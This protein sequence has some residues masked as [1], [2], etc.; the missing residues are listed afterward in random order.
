ME[1]ENIKTTDELIDDIT[2]KVIENITDEIT[3]D[4]TIDFKK[5]TQSRKWTGELSY[6]EKFGLTDEIVIAK[7]RELKLDYFCLSN[8]EKTKQNGILHKHLYIYRPT[9]IRFSRLKA[10]FP[11][12]HFKPSKAT[13]K[14]NRAYCMKL[15]ED[16]GKEKAETVVENSFFE[17][18]IMPTEKEGKIS[19]EEQ[20]LQYIEEYIEVNDIPPSAKQVID[21]FPKTAFK[22]QKI[23]ELINMYLVE[24]YSNE[25][26]DD[27]IVTFIY[28]VSG[29][30]KNTFTYNL[31]KDRG[32]NSIFRIHNYKHKHSLYD[33]YDPLNNICIVFD[34][35][36]G[37]GQIDIT[38][39]NI[40]L[41][42]FPIINLPA[43]FNNMVATYKYVFILSNLPFTR[44]YSYEREFETD[45]WR[46]FDRRVHNVWCFTR[47]PDSD[48]LKIH[49]IKHTKD[50]DLMKDMK[51]IEFIEKGEI[52]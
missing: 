48:I 14:Q 22:K 32:Y 46:A 16:V 27:L 45:I 20:V 19:L 39:M 21:T 29:V 33:R 30:G 1:N 51:N 35:F 3:D 36:L 15:E 4:F 34:E 12:G 18:G 11:K 17:E 44:I 6:A 24:K 38:D 47:E 9:S 26:R 50:I 43:R 49:K 28:S 52:K 7:L 31:F 25:P 13:A 23:D 5:D 40:Y 8:L 42:K 10:L 37:N 2:D 41:D